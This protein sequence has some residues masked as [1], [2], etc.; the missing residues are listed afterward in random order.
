MNTQMQ[1]EADDACLTCE[2]SLNKI[3]VFLENALRSSCEGI[4]VKTL[5]V[6]A[7]YSPSKRSDKW[8]K[9]SV[10]LS[11]RTLVSETQK[12][13]L[14]LYNVSEPSFCRSSEI[15]WKD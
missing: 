15:M 9:V 10:C 3:N 5:D 12:S 8:L 2:A 1:I 7:G 4:M 14:N 6:D 11:Y 13:V